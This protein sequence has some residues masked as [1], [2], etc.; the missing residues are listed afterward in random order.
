MFCILGQNTFWQLKIWD[1]VLDKQ[2][3]LNLLSQSQVEKCMIKLML[4]EFFLS[5]KLLT[6]KN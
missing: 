6:N 4:I 5:H 2:G 3:I 1:E